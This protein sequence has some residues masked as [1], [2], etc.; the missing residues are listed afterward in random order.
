MPSQVEIPKEVY[1]KQA[2]V[3]TDTSHLYVYTLHSYDTL[4]SSLYW[5]QGSLEDSQFS[6][7]EPGTL[8][9]WTIWFEKLVSPSCISNIRAGD[10]DFWII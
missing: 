1:V 6:V 5:G 10:F 7:E 8:S 3:F 9:F 2:F 4:L